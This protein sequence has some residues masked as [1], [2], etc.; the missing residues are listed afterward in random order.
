M[1]GGTVAALLEQR[2]VAVGSLDI[3]KGAEKELERS[4]SSVKGRLMSRAWTPGREGNGI[5]L[6]G[7]RRTFATLW[8]KS[9]CTPYLSAPVTVLGSTL[10]AMEAPGM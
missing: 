6:T 10:P 2:Q 4:G 3:G 1:A 9:Q 7:S 5:L 8:Q